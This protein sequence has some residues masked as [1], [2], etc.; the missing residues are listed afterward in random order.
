MARTRILLPTLPSEVE[1]LTNK[2]QN[3]LLVD[4]SKFRVLATMTRVAAEGN[5]GL[6]NLYAGWFERTV[7][8]G[9]GRAWLDPLR[10][11]AFLGIRDF[12]LLKLF[13]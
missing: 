6:Q 1:D 10:V 2:S 9:V 7:F 12:L 11:I 4:P 13:D 3:R 8:L 5:G